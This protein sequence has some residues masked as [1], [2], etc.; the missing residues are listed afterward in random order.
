MKN[1]NPNITY[2]YQLPAFEE[3]TYQS[4]RYRTIT[5]IANHGSSYL[6]SKRDVLNLKTGKSIRLPLR[7]VITVLSE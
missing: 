5:E 1:K 4:H 2:L 3:F 7:T 6:N